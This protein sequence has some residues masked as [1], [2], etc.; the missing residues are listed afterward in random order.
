MLNSVKYESVDFRYAYYQMLFAGRGDYI[1]FITM[2]P[3]T[4]TELAEVFARMTGSFHVFK[5]NCGK[6]K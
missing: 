4:C 5:N 6:N 2:G 1:I 3:R